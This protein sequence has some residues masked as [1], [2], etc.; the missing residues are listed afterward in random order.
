M[1]CIFMSTEVV[2][3]LGIMGIENGSKMDFDCE[4][5]IKQK[6]GLVYNH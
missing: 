6:L 3:C 2:T 5:D 4:S 1:S